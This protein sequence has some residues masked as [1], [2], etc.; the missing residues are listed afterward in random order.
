MED[1]HFG[2]IVSPTEK[3]RMMLMDNIAQE[4]GSTPVVMV[5]SSLGLTNIIMVQNPEASSRD[6]HHKMLRALIIASLCAGHQEVDFNLPPGYVTDAT[7][8]LMSQ[9]LN[10][11]AQNLGR[12]IM[13]IDG[14]STIIKLQQ[15]AMLDIKKLVTCPCLDKR[16]KGLE[17]AILKDTGEEVH[18]TQAKA[19]A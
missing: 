4:F 13:D 19:H 1:V 18:P 9:A 11:E 6:T 3:P 10:L 16:A 5:A 14:A 17:D 12:I 7:S 15:Q 8:I 2:L